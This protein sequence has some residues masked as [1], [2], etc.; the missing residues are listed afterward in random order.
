MVRLKA[1]E[2]EKLTRYALGGLEGQERESLEQHIH[3][4]APCQEF[5]TFLQEFNNGLREAKPQGPLPGEPCPDPVLLDALQDEELDDET[6]QHVRVHMLYCEN[7][8]EDYQALEKVRPKII[9]VVLRA[10]GSII[11]VLRPPETGGWESPLAMVPVRGE[12]V[13]SAPFRM[14]QPLTDEEDNKSRVTV[15]VD[16]GLEPDHVRVLIEGETV[17][18]RWQ[19]KVSL[20]DSKEEEWVGMPFSESP[21]LIASSIPFGLYTLTVRRGEND[22]GAFKFTVEIISVDETLELVHEYLKNGDYFR[23]KALLQDGLSRNPKNGKLLD[24]LRQVEGLMEE[25][26]QGIQ[27][28]SEDDEEDVQ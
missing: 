12:M 28:E 21:I 7:C 9:E 8:R 13:P 2:R 14:T 27:E 22:L 23:A 19:W 15:Q 5:L 20:K 24:E 6:A 1:H 10:A 4:C 16:A 25:E 11:E 17:Q 18:P 26:E 3:S